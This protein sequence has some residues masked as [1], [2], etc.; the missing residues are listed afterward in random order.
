VI[1]PWSPG[2]LVGPYR[3]ERELGR[4]GMGVVFLAQ[5]TQTGAPLVIKT[6]T[7]LDPDEVARLERE[8]LALAR[9]QHPNLVQVHAAGWH[10]RRPYLVLQ[11]ASG[12]SL[13]DRLQR[14]PLPWEEA[15][16]LGAQLAGA[17]AAAHSIGITHRDLKPANVLL[18][19]RGTPLL[20]D[21]GLAKVTDLSRLTETGAVLGTPLYMAPEQARGV[22]SGGAADVYSLG[23][24]IYAALAGRP[25]ILPAGGIVAQLLALQQERPPRLGTLA[26]LPQW[27]ER[28]IHD[29]L[30]LDPQERPTAAEIHDCLSSGPRGAPEPRGRGLVAGVFCGVTLLVAAGAWAIQRP[31]LESPLPAASSR[32][33]LPPSLTP[34]ATPTR[35]PFRLQ[36]RIF[37]ELHDQ[38]QGIRAGTL[39]NPQLP[40]SERE[41]L[42]SLEGLE[43]AELARLAGKP[44]LQGAPILEQRG[45]WAALELSLRGHL[46]WLGM[47]VR[48]AVDI[49]GSLPVLPR[50]ARSGHT[51]GQWLVTRIKPIPRLPELGLAWQDAYNYLWITTSLD[52]I[53]AHAHAMAT[54]TRRR[55]TET[56]LPANVGTAWLRVYAY[57]E[58]DTLSISHDQARESLISDRPGGALGRYLEAWRA[59]ETKSEALACELAVAADWKWSRHLALLGHRFTLARPSPS[60]GLSR[61]ELRSEIL[62]VLREV[63]WG[64]GYYWLALTYLRE[65]N[66]IRPLYPP[67]DPAPIRAAIE[68]ALELEPGLAPARLIRA[69]LCRWAGDRAGALEEVRR[70]ESSSPWWEP[71]RLLFE[72]LL[73]LEDCQEKGGPIP[74][75]TRQVYERASKFDEFQLGWVKA[76]L[77]PLFE[78]LD[79]R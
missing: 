40:E 23:A 35:E 2:A 25:P 27:L 3:L 68:R 28:L 33:P 61:G 47:A 5:D 10:E 19:G 13:E 32:T 38:L 52:R 30:A 76:I 57:E 69:Q 39:S 79:R 15:V 20:A 73:L 9:L 54:T 56:P 29:A 46:D 77:R 74:P 62:D 60:T 7:T 36:A 59:R 55:A 12:G 45:M 31:G 51:A 58:Q 21:F 42:R 53:Q 37:A 63:E 72:A 1:G 34:S 70:V 16:S 43:D 66:P 22:D 78:S 24:L 14:G 44:G 75:D 8:G 18:D 49:R 11:L 41:F 4:G 26:D 17:L 48:G 6:L 65:P 50:L 64:R 67:S 71:Q